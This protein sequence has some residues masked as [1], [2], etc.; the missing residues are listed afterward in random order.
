MMRV[1]RP[2]GLILW[3]DYHVNNPFNPDV[4]AVTARELSALFQDCDIERRR[5][6]LA[7]PLA[8]LVGPRSRVISQ[9][10]LG[11]SIPEDAL[12]GGHS[13]SPVESPRAVTLH[14][15]SCLIQACQ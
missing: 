15:G 10:S 1:V 2:G 5:V 13:G 9:P 11:D 14:G 8:R 6:T 4:R 12:S 3:Y 7:P